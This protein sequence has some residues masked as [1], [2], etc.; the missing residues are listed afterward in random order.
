MARVSLPSMMKAK[1][2]KNLYAFTFSFIVNAD[3]SHFEKEKG[4]KEEAGPLKKART[5][6]S[7]ISATQSVQQTMKSKIPLPDMFSLSLSSMKSF[8]ILLISHTHIGP[9]RQN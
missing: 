9:K 7:M 6:G 4:K 5:E 1:K 2:E 3:C 8:G